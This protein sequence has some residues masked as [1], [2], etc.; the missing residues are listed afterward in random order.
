MVP[1]N[2]IIIP[3]NQSVIPSIQVP[4][5]QCRLN[6]V[7]IDKFPFPFPQHLERKKRKNKYKIPK[8]NIMPPTRNKGVPKAAIEFE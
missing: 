6:L 1:V 4:N 2:A 3:M 7:T 8:N 5:V